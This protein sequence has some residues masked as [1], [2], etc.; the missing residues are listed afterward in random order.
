MTATFESDLAYEIFESL[1]RLNSAFSGKDFCD[2]LY[3]SLAHSIHSQNS[4]FF[5]FYAK[6]THYDEEPRKFM[7]EQLD[8]AEIRV[9]KRAIIGIVI[10][11]TQK[12]TCLKQSFKKVQVIH[13]VYLVA[14]M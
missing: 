11:P 3:G 6:I 10:D 13:G 9:G 14:E 7:T 1:E 8:Y 4:E 2:G 12:K 5:I